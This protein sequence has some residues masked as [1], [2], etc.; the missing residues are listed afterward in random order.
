MSLLLPLLA[1]LFLTPSLTVL[2]SAVL[3]QETLS[4]DEKQPPSTLV[5]SLRPPLRRYLTDSELANVSLTRLSAN[6]PGA[7]LFDIRQDGGVYT[8]RLTL[9][10]DRLCNTDGLCCE[11]DMR[12]LGDLAVCEFKQLVVATHSAGSP[13]TLEL[14]LQL[15]DLNDHSPAFSADKYVVHFRETDQIDQLVLLPLAIDADWG[16]NGIV[17]YRLR[18]PSDFFKLQEVRK[19]DKITELRLLNRQPLDRESS[20]WHSLH[21]VAEDGGRKSG[22]TLIN[23]TIDDVNDCSPEF[24]NGSQVSVDVPEDKRERSVVASVLATDKDEGQNGRVSYRLR[25]GQSGQPS[26][27]LFG[28]DAHTGRIWLYRPLTFWPQRPAS[29][30]HDLTV[31]AFDHGSPSRSA[32]ITVRI[33]VLDVN[34]HAPSIN[35][36]SLLAGPAGA[37]ASTDPVVHVLE[38]QQYGAQRPIASLHSQ[39][40]DDAENGRVRCDLKSGADMFGLQLISQ[41][42][43][44]DCIYHL[45]ALQT[46]DREAVARH[47]VTVRCSDQGQ[48]AQHRELVIRVEVDDVNDSP[49]V[50]PSSAPMSLAVLENQP[51]GAPL[52]F[53]RAEDAD[54]GP[55]AVIEYRLEPPEILADLA[56][57]PASGQLTTARSFDRE[58]QASLSFRVVAVNPAPPGFSATAEAS[59]RILDEN[60]NQPIVTEDTPRTVTVSEGAPVGTVVTRINATDADEGPQR[61]R[62]TIKSGGG[63]KFVVRNNGEI[64]LS[65]QLD[66]ELTAE[67]QLLIGV[68]DSGVP[69]QRT[70]F[71]L[72]VLVGDI[73]DSPPRFVFPPAERPGPPHQVNISINQIPGNPVATIIAH[74]DDTGQNGNVTYRLLR[75]VSGSA[76]A[77][78]SSSGSAAGAETP[79]DFADYFNLEPLTGRLLLRRRLQGVPAAD[80]C[81][82][83]G[84]G[85]LLRLEASDQG[86]PPLKRVTQLRI[87]AVNDIS[88]GGRGAG[89]G[90]GSPPSSSGQDGRTWPGAGG[91]GGNGGVFNGGDLSSAIVLLTAGLAILVLLALILSVVFLIVRR[92]AE[93]SSAAGGASA[94]VG[95]DVQGLSSKNISLPSYDPVLKVSGDNALSS[96]HGYPAQSM[97]MSLSK[98]RR[99]RGL[100]L[101]QLELEASEKMLS[102][103]ASR[104]DVAQ[105]APVEAMRRGTDPGF[106]DQRGYFSGAVSQS[107]ENLFRD[108]GVAAAGGSSATM[109]RR[110]PPQQ[111]QQQQQQQRRQTRQQQQQHPADMYSIPMPPL[112]QGAGAIIGSATGS[113]DQLRS[114]Q[115]LNYTQLTSLS[116]PVCQDY[117]NPVTSLAT[118]NSN[119]PARLP[120][121]HVSDV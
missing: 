49:P 118:I 16:R 97:H 115:P 94:G 10:R 40:Q 12:Q 64:A 11:P 109:H 32:E 117:A 57:D 75:S 73:N 19:G 53:A 113:R 28:V 119:R 59:L 63:G 36:Q 114:K 121:D 98:N 27:L 107:D 44:G 3:L 31:V 2:T 100:E 58:T 5:G 104:P 110:Q 103:A 30:W 96:L 33:R 72:T 102:S 43:T 93:G 38:N 116:Q 120:Y 101:E 50:W 34:N 46:F 67:H 85:R 56:I 77:P 78:A 25:Q 86:Q 9:D 45:L 76:P 42:K 92:R 14:T 65:G 17:S 4:F 23:V 20:A 74:D 112:L 15:R 84:S 87:C 108:V 66:R 79:T 80:G 111:Q 18:E 21:L 55:N 6:Q 89:G 106:L 8:G 60:D 82:G 52:G 7:S 1:G 83:G 54:V 90:N 26:A 51:T 61:F 35:V 39:D 47:T 62:F 70:E 71:R 68:A 24:V 48:P 91:S 99:K 69:S 41:M 81:L 105:G 22:A 88:D 95:R 37:A 13:V 29:N